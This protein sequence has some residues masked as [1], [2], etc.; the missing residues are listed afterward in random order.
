MCHVVYEKLHHCLG[1]RSILNGAP[2]AHAATS[3]ALHQAYLGNQL[4]VEYRIN[5]DEEGGVVLACPHAEGGQ[6]YPEEVS[7]QVLAY[8]LDQAQTH[9]KATISK[10]VISVSYPPGSCHMPYMP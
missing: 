1:P 10:A 8:L 4:Q 5:S 7:A 3:L 2:C 9:L 6:L